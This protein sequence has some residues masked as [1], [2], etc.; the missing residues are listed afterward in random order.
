MASISIIYTPQY[1][2]CH[3][4]Y[5]RLVGN[6]TYCLYNDTSAS[7]IDVPKE[8]EITLTVDQLT[9]LEVPDVN[10]VTTLAVEGYIQPCCAAESDL[11]TS[12]SFTFN[13]SVTKCTK[14]TINCKSAGIRTISVV[15]PG[16]G[17]SVAPGVT[18]VGFGGATATATISANSV[19]NIITGNPG[20]G[21]SYAGLPAVI[22][23]PPDLPGGV[24]A[25]AQVYELYTCGNGTGDVRLTT[26]GDESP[27]A[28]QPAQPG[29]S[30]TTCSTTF[31]INNESGNTTIGVSLDLTGCC[32][33][34]NY[35]LANDAT[36][37]ATV[38]YIN[39]DNLL[40]TYN[41]PLETTVTLCMVKDSLNIIKGYPDLTVTDLGACP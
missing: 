8:V 6:E 35:S 21:Y 14:Y 40:V 34:I 9:C 26:C 18:I 12:T 1:E 10:C 33:C 24:Q 7:E 27:K 38:Q 36:S 28:I 2:G 19:I 41:V 39:C 13:G 16:S 29:R 31:P 25:T 30:Y 11:D 5:F 4:I 23:D 22:I 17:Y 3:R 20:G 15:N 37:S 32:T